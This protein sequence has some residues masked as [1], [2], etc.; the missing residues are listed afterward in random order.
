VVIIGGGMSALSLSQK[1]Q[2][3]LGNSINIT[4]IETSDY[5]GGRIRLL[6]FENETF[7]EGASVIHG[8]VNHRNGQEN[9]VWN[10]A[11]KKGLKTVHCQEFTNPGKELALS[12]ELLCDNSD[13]YENGEKCS[14]EIT[15]L[16]NRTFQHAKSLA[17]EVQSQLGATKFRDIPSRNALSSFDWN[18]R[19]DSLL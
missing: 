8:Q 11:K 13:D 15:S 6:E 5:L 4:I 14:H 18:S 2:D 12:H 16:L 17:A 10:M 19:K 9:P 1:L 3:T 7:N